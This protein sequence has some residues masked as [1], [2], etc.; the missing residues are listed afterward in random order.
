MIARRAD[1]GAAPPI[2]GEV[3]EREPDI[4]GLADLQQWFDGLF[5]V[6]PYEWRMRFAQIAAVVT[7]AADRTP[8]DPDAQVLVMRAAKDI[9]ATIT[10]AVREVGRDADH[11]PVIFQGGMF[12]HSKLYR[13]TVARTVRALY[14]NPIRM[15]PFRTVIGAAL[16]AVGGQALVPPQPRLSAILKSIEARPLSEQADMT[17]PHWEYGEATE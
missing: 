7:E 16:I 14:P 9:A 4:G 12:E 2:F 11:L 17:Y 6:Y 10:T 15:A 13:S 1:E 8:P 3:V 5:I